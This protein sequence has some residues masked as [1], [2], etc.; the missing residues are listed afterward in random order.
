MEQIQRLTSKYSNDTAKERG[1]PP[2]LPAVSE[3]PN[4]PYAHQ[5][6]PIRDGGAMEI[7]NDNLIEIGSSQ[8]EAAVEEERYRLEELDYAL[9][10]VAAKVKE[11]AVKKTT[12]NNA[13]T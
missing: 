8:A 1:V 10:H 3:P 6:D 13:N 12:A 9:G 11:N 4:V 2:P 7:D 5:T